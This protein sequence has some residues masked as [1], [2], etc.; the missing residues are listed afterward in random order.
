MPPLFRKH[1]D[2][3]KQYFD[4]LLVV[5]DIV[6]DATCGNGH[7]SLFISKRILNKD[8]G[9][10][11]S[12]DIQDQA[13]DSAKLLIKENLEPELFQRIHFL[14]MCHSSFPSEILPGSVKLIVYN[15]GYLPGGNKEITTLSETTLKSIHKSLELV[16]EGGAISISCYPGHPAGK[17]EE[18]LILKFLSTL[19]RRKWVCCYHKFINRENAPSLLMIQKNSFK[20][21]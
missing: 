6:I 1:L 15:L 20:Q 7:D 8:N 17:I 13:L 18:D 19:D 10:L 12:L 21:A 5:G 16:S 14:K 9:T 2:L 3:C 4:K 11:F